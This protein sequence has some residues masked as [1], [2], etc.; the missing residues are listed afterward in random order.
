MTLMS[1]SGE[2]NV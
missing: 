2:I 1:K